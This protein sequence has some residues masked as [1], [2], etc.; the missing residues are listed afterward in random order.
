M[1]YQGVTDISK[2]ERGD[3]ILWN[4]GTYEHHAIVEAVSPKQIYVVHYSSDGE[5]KREWVKPSDV[6]YEL[7]G[8]PMTKKVSANDPL[9]VVI[10]EKTCSPDEVIER[11]HTRLGEK[12][13]DLA[14]N[15]CESFATWCKIGK[16]VSNQVKNV[17]DAALVCAACG[18]I[19]G[20]VICPGL[21][22][23]FWVHKYNARY[24]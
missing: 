10:Y 3:H 18:P 19:L 7:Q 1:R 11:A 6:S 8:V 23:A 20:P 13:Y 2:L 24:Q 4:H 14:V 16:N 9:Y 5:I 17:S 21:A 22:T 15:N 12:E